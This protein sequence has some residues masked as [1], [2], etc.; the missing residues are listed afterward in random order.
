MEL[1]GG[2]IQANI[3]L[4]VRLNIGVCVQMSIIWSILIIALTEVSDGFLSGIILNKRI[5]LCW[6]LIIRSLLDAGFDNLLLIS[7]QT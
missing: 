3:R 2:H 1:I 6:L 5:A 4:N 7:V